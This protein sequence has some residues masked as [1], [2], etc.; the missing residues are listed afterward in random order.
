V[1]LVYLSK[2]LSENERNIGLVASGGTRIIVYHSF[3][4]LSEEWYYPH[5]HIRYKKHLKS[6]PIPLRSG[7]SQ[8]LSGPELILEYVRPVPTEIYVGCPRFDPTLTSE[9]GNRV[10]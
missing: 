7:G 9:M 5:D 3:H 6:S 10:I 1:F 2:Y 8:V 4:Q